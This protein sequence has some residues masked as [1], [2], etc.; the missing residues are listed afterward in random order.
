[1][2]GN[3]FQDCFGDQLLFY[4]FRP[5]VDKDEWLL[6]QNK[7]VYFHNLE[8]LQLFQESSLLQFL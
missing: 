3:N 4:L 6:S 7:I 1:M 5:A 8:F 2:H